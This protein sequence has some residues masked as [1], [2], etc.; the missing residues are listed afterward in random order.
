MKGWQRYDVIFL[1]DGQDGYKNYEDLLEGINRAGI[2]LSTFLWAGR[3]DGFKSSGGFRQWAYYHTDVSESPS[4]EFLQRKFFVCAKAYLVNRDFVPVI[5]SNS[6]IITSVAGQGLPV[7]HGY[8]RNPK[9]LADV[10]LSSDSGD[11]IL[12][13]WQYGLGKTAAFTSDVKNLWTG[14]YAL[15][16]NYRHFGKMWSKLPLAR[17]K[18]GPG[19][20]V[21]FARGWRGFGDLSHKSNILQPQRYVQS[22]PPRMA[23]AGAWIKGLIPRHIYSKP[24]EDLGPEFIR[25]MCAKA[26]RRGY[27]VFCKYGA[28]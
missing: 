14:E 13:V 22:A 27:F 20:R 16:E 6:E 8:G 28:C 15:W 23:N 26:E 24:A 19:Q 5:S 4:G 3:P 2:S 1:T 21:D 10:L 17:K 18:P 11:P 12:A 7:L 9:E 25:L